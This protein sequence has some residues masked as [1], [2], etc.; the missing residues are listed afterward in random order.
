MWRRR[1]PCRWRA[2][3]SWSI[4]RRSFRR[5][6]GANPEVLRSS[7][8]SDASWLS[9]S[10]FC[11]PTR[12]TDLFIRE[13]A[14]RAGLAQDRC[15]LACELFHTVAELPCLRLAVARPMLAVLM[16]EKLRP[17]DKG[18]NYACIAICNCGSRRHS[19]WICQSGSCT[20]IRRS[21][22]GDCS[23]RNVL[24]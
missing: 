18:E 1:S 22:V 4:C 2:T 13:H 17:V 6:E 10:E 23:L 14:E 11:L 21:E 24:Q 20:G 7:F 16:K 15:F 8:R 19:A 12:C 9:R 5:A 3:T